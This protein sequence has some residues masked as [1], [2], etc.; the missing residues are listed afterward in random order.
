MLESTSTLKGKLVK[1]D[2][3][4]IFFMS[5]CTLELCVPLLSLAFLVG[6]F[7]VTAQG[8]TAAFIHPVD[9]TQAQ[10]AK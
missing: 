2:D 10:R 9:Q 5:L 4:L 7:S 1:S 3:I 6:V 8:V